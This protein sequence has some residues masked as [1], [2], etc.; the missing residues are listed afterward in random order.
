MG[1]VGKAGKT[2]DGTKVLEQ[3]GAYNTAQVA[4]LFGVTVS[5]VDRWIRSG[6]LPAVRTLGGHY[7]I[8]RSDV[9]SLVVKVTPWG[10]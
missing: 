8:T 7:R 5:T 10:V 1:K 6:R 2:T 9:D 4:K 3:S